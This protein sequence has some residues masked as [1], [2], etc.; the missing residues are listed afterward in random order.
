MPPGAVDWLPGLAALVL[1]LVAGAIY[2]WRMRAPGLAPAAMDVPPL[3]RRDLLGKR[4]ELVR[5]LVELEDTARKR[6]PEQ[7]A[8]ERYALELETA[9]VLRQLDR[10]AP[11]AGAAANREPSA[12]SAPAPVPRSAGRPAL[13]GFLWGTGSMAALIGI[14]LLV[15]QAARPREPGGTPT[16]QPAGGSASAAADPQEASLKAQVAQS[17]DDLEAHLALARLYLDRQDMMGVWN[18]T[19]AVLTR[20]P[21]NPH[22]LSYQALVRLAMGQADVARSMLEQA[23]AADPDL[24]DAYPPLSLAQ[25]R[26]GQRQEAARTMAE[27]RRRFPEQAEALTRLE[28]QLQAEGA[29][30]PPPEGNPHAA[31]PPPGAAAAAVPAR[32]PAAGGGGARQ[33]VGRIELDPALQGRTAGGVIFLMV[34]APGEEAGM[35]L[36][37][38]RLTPTSFPLRFEIGEANSMTGQ[39]LPDEVEVEARLDSDGNPMTRSP[40]DPSARAD[41]VALGT[42]DLRLVLRQAN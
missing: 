11:A 16:G 33:I 35:P 10:L 27:A 40:T 15:T 9:R 5:Q 34:R 6:S 25:L 2:V 17:P 30:E 20:S 12:E 42:S 13:R 4:D 41:R 18:E 22:A 31:V 26:L 21:G 19:Q 32:E 3:E 7:L 37:V 1:G 14:A 8:R 29:E 38:E 28:A 23:I 36:A 24:I 39:P